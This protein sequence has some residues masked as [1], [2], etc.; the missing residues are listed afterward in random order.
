MSTSITLTPEQHADLDRCRELNDV[1]N[2]LRNTQ[3]QYEKFVH[4]KDQSGEDGWRE[5]GQFFSMVNAEVLTPDIIKIINAKYPF[6]VE[7]ITEFHAHWLTKYKIPNNQLTDVNTE[8][9]AIRE[10]FGRTGQCSP[11]TLYAISA[12]IC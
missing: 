3:E 4:E 9:R 8:I 12:F 6:S 1:R 10:R 11:H 5:V 7:E 2:S